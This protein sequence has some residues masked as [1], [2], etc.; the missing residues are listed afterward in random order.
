MILFAA[1][2]PFMAVL[3]LCL[4]LGIDAGIILLAEIGL[5]YW[6]RARALKILRQRWTCQEHQVFACPQCFTRE[7]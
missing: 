7:G 4:M 1:L 6:L 5:Y 3:I 2:Y